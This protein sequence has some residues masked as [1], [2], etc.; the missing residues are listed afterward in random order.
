MLKDELDWKIVE[1][2]QENSRL[3]YASI[4]RNIGLSASAVAERIQRLEEEEIIQ[5]YSVVINPK[6]LGLTLSAYIS[7]G[8][9]TMSFHTFINE[10]IKHFPEIVQCSRVTGNDCLMMKCHLKDSTH[11]EN[12]IDRL[13]RYGSPTTLV[14]LSDVIEN[15][16]I[17][18]EIFP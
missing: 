15:G 4:G 13:S 16:E 18:K 8:I 11:L 2:L 5:G 9:H 1:L 7:I 14:V 10:T 12:L 3:S 6:K 17:R